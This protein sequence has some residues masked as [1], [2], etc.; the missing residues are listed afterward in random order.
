M[1][2]STMW[3]L[4]AWNKQQ[5]LKILVVFILRYQAWHYNVPVFPSNMLA[6]DKCG[7]ECLMR[8]K[9]E[10][11]L[12]LHYLGNYSFLV[13]SL[14]VSYAL[15]MWKDKHNAIDPSLVFFERDILLWSLPAKHWYPCLSLQKSFNTV[16]VFQFRVLYFPNRIIYLQSKIVVLTVMNGKCRGS[17][18]LLIQDCKHRGKR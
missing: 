6:F 18:L 13:V 4:A 8:K 5:K 16:R 15:L 3:K 2:L 10:I 14:I 1:G 17:C 12:I 9:E 11:V 7:F